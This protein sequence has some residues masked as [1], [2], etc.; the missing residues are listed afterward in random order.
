MAASAAVASRSSFVPRVVLDAEP[1]D[2]SFESWQARALTVLGD[3]LRGFRPGGYR[4]L[5]P[6]H[7]ASALPP[8]VLRLER[9][10]A[11]SEQW[12]WLIGGVGFTLTGTVAREDYADYTDLFEDVA[13]TFSVRRP[14]GSTT[15]DERQGLGSTG[16]WDR[17]RIPSTSCRG[18]GFSWVA[19]QVSW[20]SS[21]T[22]GSQRHLVRRATEPE[23]RNRLAG[24]GPGAQRPHGVLAGLPPVAAQG[25]L[26]GL[27]RH[28]ES[29][30]AAQMLE[31]EL[32]GQMCSADGEGRHGIEPA[33][34]EAV[35]S[36]SRLPE[37]RS[38]PMCETSHV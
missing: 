17:R 26:R 34:V 27:D 2:G 23:Q 8:R 15:R 11:V 30:P 28:R 36:T 16:A 25:D 24:L 35:G 6:R 4:R 7:R 31:V 19:W 10:R 38:P 21:N 9:P 22:V 32:S 14:G 13:G 37:N 20:Y 1:V 18:T 33:V 5:P 3:L 12:C 29:G